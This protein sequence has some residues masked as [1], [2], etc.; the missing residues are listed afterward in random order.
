MSADDDGFM[1]A[2]MHDATVRKW[3]TRW[4]RRRRRMRLLRLRRWW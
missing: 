2:V 4:R 1:F 3:E